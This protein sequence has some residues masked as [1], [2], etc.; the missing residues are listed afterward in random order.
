MGAAAGPA[1][2]DGGVAKSDDRGGVGDLFSGGVGEGD[3]DVAGGAAVAVGEDIGA[4]DGIDRDGGEKSTVFEAF[5]EGESEG[6]L[7]PCCGLD[8]TSKNVGENEAAGSHAIPFEREGH[9][10]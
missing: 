10:F 2:G 9:H 4:A 8:L 5:H 6:L 3:G 7:T 1:C